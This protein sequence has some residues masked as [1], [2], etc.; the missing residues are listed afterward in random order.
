MSC[1]PQ[2]RR[3]AVAGLFYPADPGELRSV[4]TRMLAQVTPDAAEPKA[5]IVPHAGY[6]YSGPVAASAYARL[7]SRRESIRR[8]VLLG[9]THHVHFRGLAATSA[10]AYATPLG[11]IPLDRQAIE[12]ALESDHVQTLDAAHLREHSLEVQLPF[13]QVTLNRFEL[14]P[15]VVGQ[16]DGEQTAE[17]LE[18]LWGGPETLIVISSDLSHYHDSAAA[19]QLDA[20]TCR[21][22]E[23]K[24][25]DLL[26]GERACGCR[27]ISGL[28][29]VAA[30]R[31]LAV[32]TVDLRNSGETAGGKDRVVGYGAWLV[33]EATSL[34]DQSSKASADE[35]TPADRATLMKL[36]RSAIA[37]GVAG[38]EVTPPPLDDLGPALRSERATFV[39]LHRH[40]ELRG[41]CGSVKAFEPLAW[42]V[43]RSARTAAFGDRRFAPVTETEAADLELHLSL[44]TTPTPMQFVTEADLVTQ[45]RPGID[46]VILVE[47]DLG[48]Q[49]VFLPA[50]WEQLPQ[51]RDFVR[52][53]K[54][55]AGLPPDYWSPW[56]RAQR[57]EVESI[58][59]HRAEYA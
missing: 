24:R 55:K 25:G 33:G 5:I 17:V 18:R 1:G 32:R 38:R 46:G 56:M 48:R 28:L 31:N 40:G 21:W 22:I 47:Q 53:L 51:P 36:A 14:V 2:I 52:R 8:V 50:V 6:V 19:K 45:L 9:P 7:A 35:L 11:T 20:E 12:R 3:P 13:L 23:T 16:S 58:D 57:F 42:N 49:G 41:C 29:T 44:L 34:R 26:T 27:G 15:L 10:D 39:T 37:D 30:R 4:I 54:Q 43:V 59:E